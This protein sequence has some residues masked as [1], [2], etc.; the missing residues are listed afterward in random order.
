MDLLMLDGGATYLARSQK[1]RARMVISHFALGGGAN[2]NP[3]RST[4]GF[5]TPILYKARIDAMTVSGDTATFTC[6]LPESLA[7]SFGELAVLS[8]DGGFVG[9]AVVTAALT[10]TAGTQMELTLQLSAAGIGAQMTFQSKRVYL[11]RTRPDFEDVLLQMQAIA[12]QKENFRGLVTN[13]TG[14]TLLELMAGVADFDSYAFESAHQEAFPD[15]AK[16]DS[17]QYAIQNMLGNR[18]TRRTPAGTPVTLV[19]TGAT[20]VLTIPAYHQWQGNGRSLFNRNTIQFAAGQTT[21]T[22]ILYEGQVRRASV[23]GTNTEYQFWVAPQP[24]FV[25]SDSDV[26]VDVN[27]E[28]IPVVQDGM[29]NYLDKPA[30][31]DRTDKFGRLLL[32]F[33]SSIYGT[34]PTLDETVAITYVTTDGS[35]GSDASF[36]GAQVSSGS[37]PQITATTTGPLSGGGDQP[38]TALYQRM[39]GDIFGGQRGAVTP[40]Q[41]RARARE[42]P[43]VIDAVMLAQRDLAPMAKEWFNTGKVILLTQSPWTAADKAAYEEWLRARTMYSMRYSILTGTEGD[44]EPR[45]KTIDV[46]ARI[47]CRQD[48]DLAAIQSQAEGAVRRLFLP[49]AGILSRAVYKTDITDAIKAIAPE[50]IDFVELAEPLDDIGMDIYSPKGLT[51]TIIPDVG[52]IPPGEYTFG[53]AAKDADGLTPPAIAKVTLTAANSSVKFDWDRVPSATSYV[54]YGRVAPVGQLT[55]VTTLTYTDDGTGVGTAEEPVNI[56]TSGV[57]YAILGALD[58]TPVYSRRR[59]IEDNGYGV[60]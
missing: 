32:M 50:Q 60:S 48:A 26:L 38:S 25:V 21:V 54:I 44:D 56:N 53:V 10:K 28:K 13:E 4:V 1:N 34:M 22:A 5:K 43:G 45:T 16:L 18:L 42:Y 41:Y 49:R 23:A 2:Y 20:P 19:R 39:G 30:V 33:G 14:N 3:P 47:S 24:D 6:I 17:T 8:P 55:E 46:R 52:T 11:S 12:A 29:W 9:L 57:H 36:T 40:P 58:L 51:V 15:T 59:A 31:Q 37:Y 27:G 35:A 7:L